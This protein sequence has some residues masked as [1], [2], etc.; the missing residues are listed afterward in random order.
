MNIVGFS[1]L[2]NWRT[3]MRLQLASSVG[4]KNFCPCECCFFLHIL[5]PRHAFNYM[6]DQ[7]IAA[8]N[9]HLFCFAYM[10]MWRRDVFFSH[11]VFSNNKRIHFPRSMNFNECGRKILSR[12]PQQLFPDV[13]IN[14]YFPCPW[15]NCYL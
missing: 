8:Y 9:Q 1:F 2:M 5:V 11:M 12:K 6:N 4:V 14:V 7:K 3:P 13:K 10:R 15:T